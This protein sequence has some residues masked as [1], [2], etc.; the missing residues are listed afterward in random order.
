MKT[1]NINLSERE[2]L[3]VLRLFEVGT[4]NGFNIDNEGSASYHFTVDG[5]LGMKKKYEITAPNLLEIINDRL[6]PQNFYK[7]NRLSEG[8]SIEIL[9]RCF[10]GIDGI[11]R[12]LLMLVY[13]ELGIFDPEYGNDITAY[14]RNRNVLKKVMHIKN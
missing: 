13:L 7:G 4:K 6:D 5:L 3:I 12:I 1:L 8:V 14:T 10:N 9:T 2:L 11:S